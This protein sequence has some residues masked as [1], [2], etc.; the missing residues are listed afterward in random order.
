MHRNPTRFQQ[1]AGQSPVAVILGT[2]E[3][4][5]AV[6]VMLTN[7]GY[8]AILSHDPFPP[9]IRRAMAFHDSLFGDRAIVDGIEGMRAET[10]AELATAFASAGR[11]A[12]TPLHLTDLL[13]ILSPRVLID[14]RMQ[15]YRVT[16]DFRG[17]ATVT[18]GLG[19]QFAVGANC[20]VAVETRPAK[21]GNV[22]RFGETDQPDR[23]A[24]SLGGYGA[25]RFVY[26]DRG[27]RWHTPLEIGMRVFKGVVLGHHDGH[28]VAA[29]IDGVLRGLVRDSTLVPSGVKLLEID[30]R[31]AQAQ[32][33]GSDERGRAIA[34]ATLRAIRLHDMRP[35]T[36]TVRAGLFA[37]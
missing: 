37:M 33:T 8:S 16:P 18:V 28:P 29:P 27:G 2:S 36:R 35:A 9:V 7:G 21:N 23:T 22:V 15:K 3:I 12:V 20:D 32:W 26:S 19:P 5:S 6:A 30:A 34:D 17:I 14:A 25:E 13:A 31:G 11:V 24:R 1:Q 4:A 10:A